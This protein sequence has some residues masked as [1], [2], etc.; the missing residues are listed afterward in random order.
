M[1]ASP[2]ICGKRP[3][4]CAELI[5]HRKSRGVY[6]LRLDH[7]A[8]GKLSGDSAGNRLMRGIIGFYSDDAAESSSDTLQGTPRGATVDY[9]AVASASLSIW[10][11]AARGISLP[12]STTALIV[13]V[14]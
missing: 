13:R 2:P 14:L 12:R 7:G 8:S 10:S 6:R 11:S 9:F 3:N 5:T 4:Q 1:V